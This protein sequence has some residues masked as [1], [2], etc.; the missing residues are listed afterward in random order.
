MGIAGRM[1]GGIGVAF[2]LAFTDGFAVALFFGGC[3][4]LFAVDGVPFP[5]RPSITIWPSWV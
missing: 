1:P 4:V 2:T 3:A 5:L